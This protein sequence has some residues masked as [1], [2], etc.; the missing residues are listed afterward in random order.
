MKDHL[1]RSLGWAVV[2]SSALA[3]AL[4]LATART[5][6]ASP[7]VLE[8]EGGTTD[9][10]SET[11]HAAAAGLVD[12][13]NK[14]DVKKLDI[15][16]SYE[17]NADSEGFVCHLTNPSDLSVGST[18]ATLTVTAGDTCF[19]MNAPLD[20]FS[21]TG[22]S[23]T[24]A[25]FPIGNKVVLVS[26]ASTL[27]DLFGNTVKN[28][29][30]SG[31]LDPSGAGSAQAGGIRLIE[32]GGGAIDTDDSI[33]G[34]MALAGRVHLKPIK[35]GEATASADVLDL[36]LEYEDSSF[37]EHLHCHLTTPSDVSYSLLKGFGQLKITVSGSDTCTEPNTA[38]SITFALYVGGSKG[39]IVST[40]STLKDSDHDTVG[41]VAVV[42]E[43]ST[44]GGF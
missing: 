37:G 38:K 5:A 29:A 42:G 18:T 10:A 41:D 4:A 40:A 39:R 1:K 3:L 31:E 28:V 8:V 32:A 13:N 33:S 44:P 27:K 26:T 30:I 15:T 35:K 34:H 19:E 7:R 22:N 14:G 9:S 11:G 43:I 25:V 17:D 12:F 2:S 24:F 16:I 21:N 20:T 23:V 36:D 6:Q